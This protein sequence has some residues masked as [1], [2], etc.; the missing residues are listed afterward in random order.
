M[1][2]QSVNK[3]QNQENSC[4]SIFSPRGWE[5]EKVGMENGTYSQNF[6]SIH[7]VVYEELWSKDLSSIGIAI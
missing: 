7:S 5:R 6:S 4:K 1:K 2:V 3:T